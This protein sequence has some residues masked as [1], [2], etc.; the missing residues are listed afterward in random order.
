[1]HKIYLEEEA[2]PTRDAQSR[3][4][5]YMKEVVKVEL[6]KLLDVGIIYPIL[7]SKWVSPVQ[8][9]PKKSGITMVKNEDEE[10]I[11]TRITTSWR[12]CIDYRRVNKMT[13]K[14][15]FPLPFIHQM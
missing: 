8:L 9:V 1:V 15:H 6:L 5:P 14:Y 4:N 3:L 10:L 7:D 12:V 11:P 2:K 13:R